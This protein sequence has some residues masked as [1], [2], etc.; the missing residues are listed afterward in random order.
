MLRKKKGKPHTLSVWLENLRAKFG[1]DD[2]TVVIDASQN[3]GVIENVHN[4][5]AG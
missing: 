1:R 3:T 5:N 2:N 4:S